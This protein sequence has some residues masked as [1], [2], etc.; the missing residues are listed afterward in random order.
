LGG[1]IVTL[2]EVG[3][4]AGK[5]LASGVAGYAAY[6]GVKYVASKV[7]GEDIIGEA[8]NAV[9]GLFGR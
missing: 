3:L 2:S 6:E 8:E 7:F 4:A 9:L 1:E 5:V